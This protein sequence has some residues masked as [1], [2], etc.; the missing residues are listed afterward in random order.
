M[1]DLECIVW[2][3]LGVVVWLLVFFFWVGFVLICLVCWWVVGFWLF[4]RYLWLKLVL[5][6]DMCRKCV[7]CDC[8][9]CLWGCGCVMVCRCGYC[10]LWWFLC[11]DWLVWVLWGFFLCKFV[12]LNV[13]V[14]WLLVFGYWFVRVLVWDLM[15]VWVLLWLLEWWWFWWLV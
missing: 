7:C 1:I 14:D 4:D 3:M 2:I 13:M 15:I 10:F 8:C 9:V 11:C 12:V 6:W 5:V